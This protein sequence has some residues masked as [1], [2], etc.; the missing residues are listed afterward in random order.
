[1]QKPEV[2][3]GQR[4][5]KLQKCITLA[6]LDYKKLDKQTYRTT[7]DLIKTSQYDHQIVL[8]TTIINRI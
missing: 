8:D 3:A 4:S 5:S 6:K 2:K 7:F 1:M